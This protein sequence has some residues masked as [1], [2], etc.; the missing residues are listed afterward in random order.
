LRVRAAR[1][2]S[3]A[4]A[5]I[6]CRADTLRELVANFADPSVGGV[7]GHT[8]YTLDQPRSRAATAE[9]LYWRYVHLA[10]RSWR[11]RP[12]H[13]LGARRSVMRSVASCSGRFVDGAVTDDFADPTAVI[14]HGYRL[15]F[16]PNALAT[17]VAVPEAKR[18]FRR[19]VAAH[20][21]RPARRLPAPTFAQSEEVRLLTR[22]SSPLTSWPPP[23]A[24]VA[25]DSQCR[26]RCRLVATARCIKRWC[27]RRGVLLRHGIRRVLAASARVW[28]DSGCCTSRFYILHGEC[29]VLGGVVR[30]PA[31][32]AH[33]SVA[34][35]A[36]KPP[37]LTRADG[38]RVA[39]VTSAGSPG[40]GGHED[41]VCHADAFCIRRFAGD[42]GTI[43]S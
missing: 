34:A 14:A 26:E 27:W 3:S 40:K 33:R 43:T 4:T 20:D 39:S 29:G 10:Q 11:A 23:G 38:C 35:P 13:R 31:R 17:E 2:S 12:Q 5:N 25:R 19:R 8:T 15:V 21:A 1:S 32:T 42:F 37:A 41:S 18:E 6:M 7:A 28:V 9:R 36:S 24:S 16:E 22:S 30:R